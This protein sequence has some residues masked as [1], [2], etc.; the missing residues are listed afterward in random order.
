VKHGIEPHARPG[1]VTI[2]GRLDGR[3]LRLS[4]ADTGGGIDGASSGH[5]RG[6]ELTRRRLAAVY[7]DE[8]ALRTE[9][10]DGLFTVTIELPVEADAV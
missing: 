2:E 8:A 6:L 4:V 7:G 9:R 1:T 5:G 3:R 10:R